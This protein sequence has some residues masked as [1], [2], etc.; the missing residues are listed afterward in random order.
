MWNQLKCFIGLHDWACLTYRSKYQ[1]RWDTRRNR[2]LPV[3]NDDPGAHPFGS[4]R[5]RI[6]LRCKKYEDTETGYVD[7]LKHDLDDE[8]SRRNA[9]LMLLN[10]E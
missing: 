3:G 8:I 6:C 1:I 2:H 10:D 4:V 7:Q 5:K 9:G